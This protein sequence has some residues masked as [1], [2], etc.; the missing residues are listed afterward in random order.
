ML[1]NFNQFINE[2]K[3]DEFRSLEKNDVI[4][5]DA[6]RYKV[7]SAN[8]FTISISPIKGASRTKSV[9]LAQYKEKGGAIISRAEKKEKK[10]EE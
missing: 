3:E 8:D 1:R 5:Y 6:T 4:L 9:S 2:S 7:N 10:D